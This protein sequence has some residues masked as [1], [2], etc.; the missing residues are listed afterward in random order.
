MDSQVQRD[1][2]V[3]GEVIQR[4]GIVAGEINI[5]RKCVTVEP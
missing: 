3:V 1:D 5:F 4:I 2:M